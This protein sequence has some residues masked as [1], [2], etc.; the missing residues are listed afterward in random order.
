[1]MPTKISNQVLHLVEDPLIEVGSFKKDRT[2]IL[3][4]VKIHPSCRRHIL[5]SLYGPIVGTGFARTRR[6]CESRLSMP[7]ERL[8]DHLIDLGP[9]APFSNRKFLLDSLP[10]A[11]QQR[12]H[13][14]CCGLRHTLVVSCES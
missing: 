9:F 4:Q 6:W 7:E 5:L 10:H 14:F 13:L 11:L 12:L 1:M 8:I 3:Q 2:H